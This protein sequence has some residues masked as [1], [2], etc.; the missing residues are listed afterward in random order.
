MGTDRYMTT[1]QAAK[2]LGI[3]PQT[4]R[5]W[6]R[7]GVISPAMRRRGLRIFTSE[8]LERIEATVFMVAKVEG[9]DPANGD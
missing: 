5:R 4:L 6:E 8:D 7:D 3:H 1:A 2:R 9:D